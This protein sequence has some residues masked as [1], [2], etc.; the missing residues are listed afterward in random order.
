MSASES[1][2]PTHPDPAV[3]RLL[4]AEA[5]RELRHRYCWAYDRTDLAGLVALFTDDAVCVFGPFGQWEGIDQITEGYRD[6]LATLGGKTM[7]AITNDVVTV[8]GDTAHG[9]FYLLDFTFGA[10][11]ENP[12]KIIAHYL[13]DY[14]REGSGWKIARSRI[15]FVWNEDQGHITGEAHKPAATS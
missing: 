13:E 10:P 8:D 6:S 7:H 9:E 1:I 2:T 3:Q 11:K 4:D 12:L 15:N 5:V 14:R